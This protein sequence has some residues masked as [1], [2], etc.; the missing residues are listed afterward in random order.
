[1]TQL[2]LLS[3][4]PQKRTWDDLKWWGEGEV[5]LWKKIK[6][7]SRDIPLSPPCS[8]TYRAL[9]LTPLEDTQV[10]ILGQD[11]YPDLRYAMGLAFSVK[12]DIVNYPKSL[13]N[14]FRE[15]KDDTGEVLPNGDLIPWAKQGVLLLNSV[16]TTEAGRSMAHHGLGWEVFTREV[17]QAV[18]ENPYV[19]FIA[20]GKLAFD[21]IMNAHR[22]M[23]HPV[24]SS[25]HPSPMSVHHGFFGSKPFSK[26]NE[27]LVKHGLKPIKWG[28]VQTKKPPV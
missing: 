11:P 17:L 14:I 7:F 9:M 2:D 28:E 27:K 18:F 13:Q 3:T 25:A 23:R 4:P 20:W 19:V 10:V 26:T 21:T 16:L 5:Q 15:L 8:M 1:M 24:L 6:G 22:P 12:P